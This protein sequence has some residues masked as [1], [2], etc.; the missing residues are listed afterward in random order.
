VRID[1]ALN[2]RRS[3][4]DPVGNDRFVNAAPETFRKV[5]R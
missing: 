2:R 5:W 3:E 1:E 4:E